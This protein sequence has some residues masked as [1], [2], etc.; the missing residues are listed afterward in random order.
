[1]LLADRFEATEVI[2]LLLLFVSLPLISAATPTLKPYV[3]ELA[4]AAA[5]WDIRAVVLEAT[6]VVASATFVM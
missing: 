1:M 2:C 3:C 4:D 6:F 5:I